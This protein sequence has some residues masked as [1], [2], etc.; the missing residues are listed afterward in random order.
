MPCPRMLLHA[1]AKAGMRTTGG[2]IVRTVKKGK[3]LVESWVPVMER[4]KDVHPLWQADHERVPG[5]ALPKRGSAL[6]LYERGEQGD[7]GPFVEGRFN[8]N[9]SP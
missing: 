8:P 3:T 9:A 6:R 2:M 1:A 7:A 5:G 4:Q